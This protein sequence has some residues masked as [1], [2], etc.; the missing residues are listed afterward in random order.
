MIRFNINIVAP[1]IK[2]GGGKELLEYLLEYLEENY[3]HIH[4]TVYLDTSMQ[5][6]KASSNMK[7][8]FLSNYFKKIQLFCKKLEH[9]LYFGNLPPLRKSYNSIVY[10]HNPYLLMNIKKLFSSSV[11]FFIKYSLQQLYIMN[12][13]KNVNSVAC[14]N[15]LIKENFINKYKYN[16]VE[17]LPF[18]RLC[19]KSLDDYHIKKYDFCYVS[20]AHPHKNHAVLLDAM[21]I[22]SDSGTVSSL[23]V[24]IEN[25]KI[26]LINKINMINSLGVVNIKNLGV[27]P[28][29]EVCM[30]YAD[31]KCMVFPSKEETFGLGLIEAVD[32]KLDVIAADLDYVYQVIS[33][34]MVFNSDS[35]KICAK[36]M[37][38]YITSMKNKKSIGLV[39]NEID[40]LID[41]LIRGNNY[42]Q[43]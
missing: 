5:H 38:K 9:A 30:L 28:K 6:I 18:F 3:K 21:K 16:N 29:S 17:I 43:K 13:I 37:Q 42:V 31:S 32:M 20:L 7:V 22:L 14:Q 1:N 2:S 26:E 15:K 36:V 19:K 33:P 8:V 25:D 11:P 39:H 4:V 34:S 40:K 27:I 35:A 41:K 10:F 12:F 23:A 24:T